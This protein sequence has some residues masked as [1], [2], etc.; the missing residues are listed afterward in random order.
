MNNP[1]LNDTAPFKAQPWCDASLPMSERIDDM[2]GRMSLDEKIGNL[3]NTATPIGSLGLKAYQW[4]SEAAHGVTA[5]R[6]DD[7]TPGETNFPFPITLGMSF[8]RSLW[9]SVGATVGVEARAFMNAGNAFSTFWAPVINLAREPRWGRNIETPGEDPYLSGEYAT[10][11]VQG[12]QESPEDPSHIQAS[13]C[14][15][16]YAANEMEHSTV[17]GETWTRHNFSADITMQDLVDSYL[18]PFQACVEKGKV[19]GLMCSYNAI[20][21]VPS[22]ANDWLLQTVARESWGFDGYVTSDCGADGNVFFDHHFTDTPEE[23]VQKVLR[24]GTDSDCGGFVKEYAQSALDKGFITEADLDE[25]LRK[26]F[27]VRMRLGHFDPEGPL[28]RI[29][30]SAI[31]TEEA[32]ELARD[33]A[34]QSV[35]LLKNDG[36]LPLKATDIQTAVVLGPH[37]D[38]GIATSINKYYGPKSFCNGTD[39][40]MVDAVQRHVANTTSAKGVPDIKSEDIS[41]VPAAA[42]M[43]QAADAVVLVVGVDM[44]FAREEHDAVNITLPKGQ[45][46]LVEAVADAARKPIVV[47]TLTHIP[48][49]ISELLGNPK[50]GAVVHAGQA[51]VQTL[52]IGDVLFGQRSP[53]G[54]AIQ[55]IYPRT[56]QDQVSIFDFNMR[57]GPSSWPR[58]DC[59]REQWGNC[60][61]GTNPGR[62]YRFYTGEAVVPF[63]FGLSYTTFEYAVSADQQKVSL[64][65]LHQELSRVSASAF[66]VMKT[67]LEGP[68]AQYRVNVTNTGDM[69]SDEVVLGF[70]EAPGAGK[71]G[72]PLQS[73]FGFERVHV[74]AG[75]TVSVFLYPQYSDFVRVAQDGQRSAAAGE[76]RVS[77]GVRQGKEHGMAFAEVSLQAHIDTEELV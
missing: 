74:K 62:T 21:G 57:P 68:A 38:H 5:V 34:A 54:R 26:L 75:Q 55:T 44:N 16:H 32:K 2:I 66:P 1:C 28:Q 30:P 71:D 72:V 35:T 3:V 49:D 67:A 76:Y 69:D 43:A 17:A 50:I 12:M 48:L 39:L 7:T 59:P 64:A 70:L 11:F 40:T 33:S 47:V 9:K 45:M 6:N 60:T 4:W 22:C 29:A 8:N 37:T 73:L 51:S 31:C 10:A 13:A 23:A 18:A 20:N 14:C 77:F 25:R 65:R 53:A 24:A 63:G 56:Y 42:A 52:G 41:G 58:P 46:A 61:L 27:A 15:K 19:S 36:V